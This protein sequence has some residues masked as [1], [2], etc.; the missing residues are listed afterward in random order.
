MK[1]PIWRNIITGCHAVF[2]TDMNDLSVDDYAPAIIV[3]KLGKDVPPEFTNVPVSTEIL[4]IPQGTV[5]DIDNVIAFYVKAYVK[6][7]KKHPS[8]IA[9]AVIRDLVE[10]KVLNMKQNVERIAYLK[11]LVYGEGFNTDIVEDLL[12]SIIVLESDARFKAYKARIIQQMYREA[13]ANPYMLLCK[14]RLMREVDE[15]ME[16]F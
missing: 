1:F 16:S 15:M 13:I 7:R 2:L 5:E 6:N 8:P 10:A 9:L 4:W 11:K 14:R 12:D 3:R